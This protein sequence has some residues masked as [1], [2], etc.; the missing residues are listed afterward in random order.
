M[1]NDAELGT[2][3][4]I[5]RSCIYGHK[6]LFIYGVIFRIEDVTRDD[7]EDSLSVMDRRYRRSRYSSLIKI[8]RYTKFPE[9]EP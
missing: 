6:K 2:Q 5:S 9:F 3:D 1:C 8:L 7:V 4:V